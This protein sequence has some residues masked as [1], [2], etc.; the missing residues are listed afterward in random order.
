VLYSAKTAVL[1]I[2]AAMLA[3]AL[4]WIEDR[5]TGAGWA[6]AVLVL[7]M[8]PSLG[9]GLMGLVVMAFRSVQRLLGS[10]SRLAF[11]DGH[12]YATYLAATQ[13]VFFWGIVM[14]QGFYSNDSSL[15]SASLFFLGVGGCLIHILSTARASSLE[16]SD[17]VE[18]STVFWVI[19]FFGLV[20]LAFRRID[21]RPLDELWWVGP[22]LGALLGAGLL[23][24]LIHPFSPRQILSETGT[25]RRQLLFMAL[26]AILPLGGLAI[27]VWIWLRHRRWP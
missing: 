13:L 6:T 21:Y 26:T 22:A 3:S 16:S 18:N 20:V 5:Q 15:I 23:E 8:L 1:F 25:R 7:L 2:E 17:K 14:G 10:A 11:L 27:P 24:W 9:L 12:P 19:L 4:F